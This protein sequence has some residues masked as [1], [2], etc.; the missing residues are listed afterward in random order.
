MRTVREVTRT[1]EKRHLP[2]YT[3]NLLVSK[4]CFYLFFTNFNFLSFCRLPNSTE[5]GGETYDSNFPDPLLR[6]QRGRCRAGPM[7]KWVSKSPPP[8]LGPGGGRL[9]C[10]DCP[11]C[12]LKLG[13]AGA[14]SPQARNLP[15][16]F[17]S[18]SPFCSAPASAAHNLFSASQLQTNI[19]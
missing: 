10:K 3:T 5:S 16:G 18:I 7:A 4:Y 19:T 1:T 15:G 2:P 6:L 14:S 9:P 11:P 17:A 8:D 12:S 13:P